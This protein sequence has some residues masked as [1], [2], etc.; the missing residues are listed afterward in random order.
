MPYLN[1]VTTKAEW[2]GI[3]PHVLVN[4]CEPINL[5]DEPT[6][7]IL[8]DVIREMYAA[9]YASFGV[10]L[11]APQV[12]ILWQLAVVDLGWVRP[13]LADGSPLLL[14]NATYEGVA[15]ASVSDFENCMSLPGLR[16]KVCRYEEIIVENTTLDGELSRKH[17]SGWLA[18]VIQHELDHLSGKLYWS[19]PDS[20]PLMYYAGSVMRIVDRTAER[21][22]L[23]N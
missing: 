1:I 20:E 4:P 22:V 2:T 23:P 17:Y 11:A 7:R 14:I 6:R 18:R 15:E 3:V 8:P 16:G 13:E 21:L 9:M 10:G 12:G 5:E 19:K